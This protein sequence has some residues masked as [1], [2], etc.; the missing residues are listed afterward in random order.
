MLIL[1]DDNIFNRLT[2]FIQKGG[3]LLCTIENGSLFLLIC[4]P[5]ENQ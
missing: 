3:T 5:R 2:H 1:Y 4:L